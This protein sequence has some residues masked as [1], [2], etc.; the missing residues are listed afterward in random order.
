M[1]VSP[2][3][4]FPSHLSNN[5]CKIPPSRAWRVQSDPVEIFTKR[6]SGQDRFRLLIIVRVN[7][8]DSRHFFGHVFVEALP[9]LDLVSHRDYQR[10]RHRSSRLFSEKFRADDAGDLVEAADVAGA[11]DHWSESRMGPANPEREEGFLARR[12]SYPSCHG[13]YPGC[14]AEKSEQWRLVE[15]EI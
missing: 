4:Q 7:E 10:V 5:F 1:I 13:C 8:S 9:G 6:F 15:T 14:L 3:V 11:G 12:S 2:R